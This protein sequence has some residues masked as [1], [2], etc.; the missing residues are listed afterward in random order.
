[1]KPKA[2]AEGVGQQREDESIMTTYNSKDS[3]HGPKHSTRLYLIYRIE[4]GKLI[5]LGLYETKEAAQETLA[6]IK[7]VGWMMHVI[8]ARVSVGWSIV[9][10]VDERYEEM[11]AAL[12]KNQGGFLRAIKAD[13]G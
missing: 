13:E 6:P 4:D 3:P 5:T 8:D 2:E 7:H 10:G 11:R 9:N 1:M 12:A